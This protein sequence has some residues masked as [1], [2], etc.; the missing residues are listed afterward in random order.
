MEI[1][2][3]ILEGKNE[4]AKSESKNRVVEMEDEM[5]MK[6]EMMMEDEM[7]M[8]GIPKEM[9]IIPQKVDR[10]DQDRVKDHRSDYRTCN[11]PQCSRYSEM[12]TNHE[13]NRRAARN[14]DTSP[15][16]GYSM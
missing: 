15:C 7:E 8:E 14:P 10:L 16:T 12:D 2:F 6:D 5:E 11:S 1:L 3:H 4:Y 9:R 13:S